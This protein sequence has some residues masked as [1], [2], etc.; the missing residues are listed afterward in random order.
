MQ[1]GLIGLG[2]MGY[3]LAM[4]MLDNGHDVIASD[5]DK[6]ARQRLVDDS[7]NRATAAS[8]IADLVSKLTPP[9]VIWLMVP[10]GKPVDGLVDELEPLLEKGDIVIDAGNSFYKESLSHAA[11]LAA[12][13]IHFFDVGTSGGM[14]GARH[15]ACYMIGGDPEVFKTIEPIFRDTAVDKGY[16]YTGKVGSGHFCKMVHNGVEYGMMAAIGE[17]FELLEKSPFDYHFADV[18]QCWAHG[19]VIRGWLME[20]AEDAFRKDARLDSIKGV[21]HSSGEGQWTVSEALDLRTATPVIALAL[22]MR[23]RSGED[24]TFTGKVQAALRNQFGGHAV[25]KA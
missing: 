5:L 12:H 11:Q 8:S 17:G 18:A 23:Y 22:M 24:D 13:D 20:L 21:V 4:N 1:I 15:G 6:Q 10:H 19:S 3:N 25:E 14:E 2:K 7:D 16:V 9:R